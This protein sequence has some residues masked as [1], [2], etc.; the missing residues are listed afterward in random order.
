MAITDGLQQEIE[1][2]LY[3][4]AA[5]LDSR[6]FEDWLALLAEDVLY[7][8]PN[9]Q[10]DSDPTEDGTIVYEDYTGLQARVGKLLHPLNPTQLPPPR[11]QHM[12]SNVVVKENKDNEVLV[13]SNQILY[14]IQGSR[15]TD[16]PGSCEHVLLRQAGQRWSIRRKKITLISNDQPLTYIPLF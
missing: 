14:V 1:Q 13:T 11:T 4:E 10:E 15:K 8:M 12:V 3:Q 6:K 7:W 2:F 16:F 9:L 5:L